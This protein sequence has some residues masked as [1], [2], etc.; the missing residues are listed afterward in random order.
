MLMM[1]GL[2]SLNPI[3]ATLAQQVD[4]VFN[5]KGNVAIVQKENIEQVSKTEVK[6][7]VEEVKPVEQPQPVVEAPV[8]VE[9]PIVEEPEVV[10]N[11]VNVNGEERTYRRKVNIVATHY[12][13]SVRDCG[14]T[15]GITAS[16]KKV[17]EGMISVPKNI[18]F[19]T[20][21]VLED[22]G[23]NTKKYVAEDTGSAIKWLDEDTMKVDIFV[24]DATYEELMDLGKVYYTGYILE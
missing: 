15:L 20:E 22:K 21:I 17:R 8:V 19:G 18:S 4:T 3:N 1:Y 16:G 23:G 14:N 6:P 13:V 10:Q 11:T 7:V 5:T 12:T 9:E 24:P 2:M